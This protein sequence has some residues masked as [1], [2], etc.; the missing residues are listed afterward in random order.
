MLRKVQTLF[1][2][3]LLIWLS[4]PSHYNKASAEGWPYVRGLPK[5]H[6]IYPNRGFREALPVCNSRGGSSES[7]NDM[8]NP[9]HDNDFM[10]ERPTPDEQEEYLDIL[11]KALKEKQKKAMDVIISVR[12]PFF[13][14]ENACTSEVV[15]SDHG[16]GAIDVD[17]KCLLLSYRGGGWQ[18][19]RSSS[20]L[21]SNEKLEQGIGDYFDRFGRF[22]SLWVVWVASIQ[23]FGKAISHNRVVDEV[24]SLH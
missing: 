24:R 6:R 1:L 23:A 18:Q 4:S 3:V 5:N 14:D 22:I 9:E 13:C 19:R 8:N 7:V 20:R 12:S 15:H 17:L 2:T 16:N 11:S 21:S 10:L